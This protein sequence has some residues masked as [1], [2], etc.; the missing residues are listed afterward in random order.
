MRMNRNLLTLLAVGG[1][2]FGAGHLLSEY[3]PLALAGEQTDHEMNSADMEAY[4]AAGMPGENHRRLDQLIGEWD[5]VFKIWMAPDTEPM[6]SRGTVTR[7]WILGGR[8]VQETVEATSDWGT[9]TGM[10]IIG[11]D[12]VDGQY[13]V[14]WIDSMSTGI[15]TE[16]GFYDAGE[17]VL[18]MRGSLRDPITGKVIS[19][20]GTL[21][22]SNPDAHIGI[23]YVS[24]SD[25][26][27]F[28][29]FEG[30]TSRKR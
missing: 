13:E 28:K 9:F 12:N 29:H 23:G 16:T 8:Y 6:I 21:D 1:L 15:Y 3:K 27:S 19:T 26:K 25:G 5:G 30:I 18:S 14:A 20:W 22:L 11:Y 4:T 2:A 10:G 17:N 24:G 7:E